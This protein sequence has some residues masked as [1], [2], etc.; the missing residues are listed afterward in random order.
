M[1][2]VTEELNFDGKH[3]SYI[4]DH[5]RTCATNSCIPGQGGNFT[6]SRGNISS[7]QQ[8]RSINFSAYREGML[9][10]YDWR[11]SKILYSNIEEIFGADANTDE[12]AITA[13][14]DVN[15]PPSSQLQSH[16]GRNDKGRGPTVGVKHVQTLLS[17]DRNAGL[18]YFFTRTCLDP[19]VNALTGRSGWLNWVGATSPILARCLEL[20][21][22]YVLQDKERTVVLLFAAMIM[23][24]FYTLTVKSTDKPDA[25]IEAVRLF[26]D[27]TSDAQVFI[28]NINIMSVKN[29]FHNHQERVLLT[30]WSR[31]L[32]DEASL[33]YWIPGAHCEVVFFELMKAYM[34]HPFNRCAWVVTYDR[35][36]PKMEYYTQMVVKLGHAC[37][38]LAK[39]VMKTDREQFWTENDEYLMVAMLE[40]SQEIN[41]EEF[42]TW[43][44][45]RKNKY[46]SDEFVH[47]EDMEG[48]VEDEDEGEESADEE[49][50]LVGDKE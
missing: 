26:C 9:I 16:G 4:Q 24:G 46:K 50:G 20:A 14:R 45:S 15:I 41:V 47:P 18:D 19:D 39:L 11:N 6:A 29:S 38:A 10:A 30:K 28:A 43:L 48:E 37:S 25:K 40:M 27:P 22:K 33:P 32:S 2:I 23:A 31:Q 36:S 8:E 21:H 49:F 42:E 3:Q 5:G 17:Y 34:N 44:T 35:D 1:T 12:S 13:F 7:S